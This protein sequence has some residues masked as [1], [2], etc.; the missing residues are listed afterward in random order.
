MKG[1]VGKTERYLRLLVA[2]V[3]A[4]L[5]ALWSGALA[6]VGV[7]VMATAFVGWC[8]VWAVFGVSTCWDPETIPADTTGT[9][10]DEADRRRRFK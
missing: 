2:L 5:G 1:N 9:P 7:A 3:L 8:P 10:K 4:G 6:W